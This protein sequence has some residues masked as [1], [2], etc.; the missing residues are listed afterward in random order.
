VAEELPFPLKQLRKALRERDI[1]RLEIRKRGVAVEPDRLRLD[2]KLAGRSGATLV[3]L[4][5][6]DTPRAFLCESLSSP[7]NDSPPG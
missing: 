2:L 6:G 7:G 1:G 3:L 5:I 4:R